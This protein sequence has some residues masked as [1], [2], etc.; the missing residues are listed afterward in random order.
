MTEA[1]LIHEGW[2]VWNLSTYLAGEF[3]G[4]GA[5][6]EGEQW[7]SAEIPIMDGQGQVF[8][9]PGFANESVPRVTEIRKAE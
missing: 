9:V 1:Q 3:L 4:D 2:D 8:L 5:F 6:Y 7:T